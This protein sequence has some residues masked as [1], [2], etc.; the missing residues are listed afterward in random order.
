[1]MKGVIAGNF[2]V[3]HPGYIKM[4]KE[5]AENCECLVVL[6]HSDPSIER[7]HK[8]K[9]ILT[10]KERTEML[11]E[12]KSVCEVIDYTYEAQLYELLKA[13]EFDIRFLGS[14]YINEPFTGDDLKIPIHYL[15][16]SHGWSTT[17]FK[18]L[19][20]SSI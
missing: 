15:D 11:L 20:A 19:I 14:D 3:M 13:G 9:P 6:L 7:P 18:N 10:V 1:M 12:L 8:I 5:C 2:D 17:K 16:R 4:F